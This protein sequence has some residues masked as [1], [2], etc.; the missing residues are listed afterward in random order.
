VPDLVAVLPDWLRWVASRRLWYVVAW[1]TALGV[2]GWRL[3]HARNEF[4][5]KPEWPAERHRPDGNRGHTFIDFGGQWV[6]AHLLVTG[7]GHELYDRSAQWAVVRSAFPRKD[8]SPVQLA[9]AESG[10]SGP[11]DAAAGESRHDAEELM[12]C[13]MG[14]DWSGWTDAGGAVAGM[15]A[16]IGPG[17][18]PF[19]AAVAWRE[20]QTSVPPDELADLSKRH[21]GGPLYPPVHPFFYA[22]LGLL[23]PLEAFSLFQILAVGFG[24]LAGAGASYGTRGRLWA[25]VATSLFFLMP[26]CRP[27]IDLG[28]NP[29]ITAA[30]VVWGWA[31]AARGR[32]GLGGMVWGL[33]AFKPIWGLAFVLVPILS[34]RWRFCLA[35]V[36]TG[37]G[38]AAATLPVVG[39][40][41][42]KD[43]LDVGATAAEHYKVSSS[44]NNLSRDTQGIVRRLAI[45]FDKPPDVQAVR[46][47]DRVCWGIQVATILVTAV[48][49]LTRADR[50]KSWGL[51]TAFAFFGAFLSCYRFMYYDALLAG[52]GWICLFADRSAWQTPATSLRRAITNTVES[53]PVMLLAA[54]LFIENVV[55]TWV[56]KATAVAE[57]FGP[58]TIQLELGY[59][60]AWD[61]LLTVLIWL[62]CGWR[63]L[64]GDDRAAQH[65]EGGPDVGGPHEA[66]ADEDGMHARRG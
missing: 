15:F 52:V 55:W 1:V 46:V 62:W 14:K 35:M 57:G 41:T 9:N 39:I 51:G 20:V 16:Q 38:L 26:G 65:R 31:F 23:K 58:R 7:H 22:P 36:A 47:V 19:A 63:L 28:Q 8:E 30:I 29:L 56:V 21:V 12:R 50:H 60:Y 17:G 32:D 53:F 18:N 13:F 59:D 61:T 2:A 66:L 11:T 25:P 27:G 42:W 24:F 49:Y 43:W 54:V 64:L 4:A 37:L 45:D 48:I 5:N 6:L 44:W 34:R 3:G 10:R 33:L 40:Q